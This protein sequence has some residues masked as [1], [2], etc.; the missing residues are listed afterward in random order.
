M[1]GIQVVVVVE[2]VEGVRGRGSETGY[3]GTSVAGGRPL[4]L[5]V[6]GG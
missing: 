2:G 5:L 6:V 1:G 4:F 3:R